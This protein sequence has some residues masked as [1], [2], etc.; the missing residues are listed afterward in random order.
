MADIAENEDLRMLR[1]EQVI[2]LFPV[3][4]E[5]LYRM[6]NAGKFPG[7]T[8]LGRTSLWRRSQLRTWIETQG[9]VVTPSPDDKAVRKIRRGADLV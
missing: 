1:I 9:G 8:K 3:S 5:T 2:D 4:R 7:P 6:I